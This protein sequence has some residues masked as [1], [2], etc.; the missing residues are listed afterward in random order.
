M[1]TEPGSSEVCDRDQEN[2]KDETKVETKKPISVWSGA[3]EDLHVRGQFES[4]R[5]P[6]L[7]IIN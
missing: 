6:R 2:S 1:G 5:N 3:V 7:V 4:W